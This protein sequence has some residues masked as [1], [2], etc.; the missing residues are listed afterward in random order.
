MQFIQA[1]YNYNANIPE[2]SE[3][4]NNNNNNPNNANG[5]NSDLQK[6]KSFE[7]KKIYK[8]GWLLLSKDKS[9]LQYFFVL[10]KTHI[11]YYKTEVCCVNL[12]LVASN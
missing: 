9:K 2:S 6:T 1:K 3:P 8:K 4:Q 10:K 12:L 11:N 5:R 7:R